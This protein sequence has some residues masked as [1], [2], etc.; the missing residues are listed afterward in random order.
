MSFV[1]AFPVFAAV[2]GAFFLA[3]WWMSRRRAVLAASVAWLLYGVY[4]TGMRLRW[5]CSGE[6]NIRVDLVLIYPAL[7]FLS[8]AAV[9]A[10]A[11]GR[12]GKQK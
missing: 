6:C 3:A 5:L 9:G 11:R 1:I 2:P 7:L 4:E 10:L 8:V 12:A